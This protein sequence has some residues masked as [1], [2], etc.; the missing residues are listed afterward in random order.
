MKNSKPTFY[1]LLQVARDADPAA[2]RYA[3]RFQSAMCHPD[4][5]E[6][7]NPEKF[8]ELAEAWRILSDDSKRTE[9]DRT[10]GPDET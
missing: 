1:D 3:Y 7:G 9:Y 10:L 2:I 4:N 6:T 5:T 8:R